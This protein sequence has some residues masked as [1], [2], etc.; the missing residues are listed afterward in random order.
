MPEGNDD[1]QY[2]S[3]PTLACDPDARSRYPADGKKPPGTKIRKCLDTTHRKCIRS[4]VDPQ[5]PRSRLQ[6]QIAGIGAHRRRRPELP[7]RTDVRQRSRCTVPVPRRRE[8]RSKKR[9]RLDTTQRQAVTARIELQI[10]AGPI[11][12]HTARNETRNTGR[13]YVPAG[14]DARQCS[15]RVRTVPCRRKTSRNKPV[16]SRTQRNDKP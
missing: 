4:K 14:T 10:S 8:G 6:L 3:E 7:E 5:I 11:E 12:I 16:I 9:K 2:P 15:R 1:Q 13:P